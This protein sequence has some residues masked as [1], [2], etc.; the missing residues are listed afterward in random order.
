MA[1]RVYSIRI[2]ATGALAPGAGLVGPVVPAGLVYVLR[3]V[4]VWNNASSSAVLLQV[5]NPVGGAL[6]SALDPSQPLHSGWAWRGRQ[7]YA[8]GERVGFESFNGTWSVMASGYQL[9]LP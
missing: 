4:D 8:E 1:Q 5:F 7:V 3:D 2:F 6:W 9:T